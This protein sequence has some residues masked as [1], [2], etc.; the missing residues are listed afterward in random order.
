MYPDVLLYIDQERM[1]SRANS[2]KKLEA[3]VIKKGRLTGVK[4]KAT[5]SLAA[6]MDGTT[7]PL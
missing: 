4:K 7:L 2:K 5:L 1:L 6:P 3:V